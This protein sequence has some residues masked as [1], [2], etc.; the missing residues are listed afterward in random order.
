MGYRCDACNEPVFL[1]FRVTGYG[2]PIQIADTP[3][4][5]QRSAETFELNYLPEEVSSDFGEALT[6]YSNS[7]DWLQYELPVFTP[8]GV[9]CL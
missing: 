4:E 1:K 9:K 6:C 8:L 3:V 5:I 7:C 2:S